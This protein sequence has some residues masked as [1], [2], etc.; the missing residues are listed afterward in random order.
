[1][2]EEQGL[3]DFFDL[4]ERVSP[5][6]GSVLK[7]HMQRR[8]GVDPIKVLFEKPRLFLEV[9]CE[10]LGGE[11]ECNF[12]LRAVVEEINAIA[13]LRLPPGILFSALKKGDVKT[14]KWLLRKAKER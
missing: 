13:K 10:L 14:I 5:T 7:F 11:E 3:L 4:L 9:L 6:F 8:L 12:V 2:T 1:M